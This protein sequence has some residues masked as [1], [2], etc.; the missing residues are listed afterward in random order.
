MTST[1]L[2]LGATG[3]TGKLLVRQLLE[4]GQEV[5]AIVRSKERLIKTLSDIQIDDKLQIIEGTVLEMSDDDLENCVKG[6]DGIVSCLGHN[7]TTRGM[8]G[9]P[10][11]LVKDSIKRVCDTVKKI[12]PS[13]PTK[14]ILMGSNG[15]ANPDGSDDIR[16][17]GERMLIA[18]LRLLVPPV[19]DN[20]VAAEYLS[21]T[22]G[23]KSPKLEWAIVRPDD[24]VDGE[25]SE[26]K[27]FPKPSGSLFGGGETTRAN[28]A[29]FIR[30]LIVDDDIWK[31]WVYKLPYLQNM[32]N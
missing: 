23:Q 8:F 31:Q 22:V 15:V 28:V 3:A 24:L 19:V 11:K 2:V 1:T 27:A 7:M 9:H 25:V 12:E 21:K 13:Q 30:E 18:L 20:E 29:A 26:Y 16:P 10:R 14:I 5:R 6:S 32:T 17:M 4:E